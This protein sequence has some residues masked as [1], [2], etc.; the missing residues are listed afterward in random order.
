MAIFDTLIDDV[1]TQF[2]L[3]SNAGLIVR[4]I[5]SAITGTPGGVGGFLNNLKTA[6]LSSEVAS[7]LGHANAAPLAAA[8]VDRA[9]GSTA[10]GGIASRLGLAPTL[11]SS[12]VGYALPKVISLL[13]PGGVIPTSLPAEVTNFATPVTGPA[14]APYSTVRRVA[15]PYAAPTAQV[16]P[17]RVDVYHAPEAHDEPAMTGWLWPLLGALAVL[18]LGL[19]FW[20]TGNRTVAPPIAQ[21][22]VVAPAPPA[23]ALVPPRLEIANDGG[24]VRISGAVHDDATKTNILNALRAVFGADKVQGDIAVD[25]NRAAAPWLVNFR[26]G[27]EALKIPDVRA[28]FDGNSV[29]LG[30]SIGEAD[31]NRVTASIRSVLGGNLV[32]G[33]LDAKTTP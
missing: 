18:G 22:P 19:L 23:P 9:F 31:L 5:L 16:A 8:Q 20:P 11:V 25:L 6:G 12:A 27:I 30:G 21:A 32:F 26:N 4:E 10:I 24:V 14:A 15:T 28:V 33:S 29:N 13:T 2:G 7:W 17:R 3:G 1:A